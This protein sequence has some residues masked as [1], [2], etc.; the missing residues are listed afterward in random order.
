M[1]KVYDT[2]WVMSNNIPQKKQVFA[3]VES[4]DYAKKETELF[5]HVVNG[6]VGAGWG[7]DSGTKLPPHKVFESK[8]A[9][10]ESL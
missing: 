6:T 5:Y 10:L 2:V 7:T 3:V 4:M 9:L 1:H 8:K